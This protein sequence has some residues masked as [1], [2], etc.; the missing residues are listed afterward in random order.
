MSNVVQLDVPFR[1]NS[2]AARQAAMLD[3]FAR[4]RRLDGDVFWLKENAEAL[5]VLESTAAVLPEGA[6][7]VHRAF[8]DE[9]ERRMGFFPQYYR[10]F[11]G[12]CLDL[13]DLGIGGT[14]GE[15]L[16]RWVARQGLARAELSDLQRA[17]ARRLCLRRGVDPVAEDGG[18]NDRL[19]GFVRRSET[20]ALPN[21]KAAY[22]L[23][24][25]VFYLSEYG[26]RDPEV[27]QAFI[28]SL[29]FAGTLAFL[30]LNLDL[31]AEICIALRFAGAV[32]PEVWE[33]WMREQAGLFRLETVH[34]GGAPQDDY[35]P[36]LVV[37]WAMVVAGQG[38][39][40]QQ[41]PEGRVMFRQPAAAVGPL[42]E[43]S[44]CIYR[45]DEAR[46]GDWHQMRDR[47]Q[48]ALSDEARRVLEAAEAATDRF[49]AFFAGFARTGQ[50]QVAL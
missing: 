31:L 39:F 2:M 44:E 16:T 29:H 12:L 35:H 24:H 10:F 7:R 25:I 28:D 9:I 6:L 17:E 13:E 43:L 46:S 36:W 34:G 45:M 27:G 26:R 14:K 38:G 33:T 11:L 32:P 21:K 40:A 5:N 3:R 47:V 18:L 30:E 49:E 41:I 19:R 50:Q 37:N 15:G 23:T 20:F 1:Q 48:E 4:H 22:E 42:R 8:Y